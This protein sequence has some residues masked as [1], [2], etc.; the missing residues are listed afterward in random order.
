M[1]QRGA[2]FYSRFRVDG[3][4]IRQCLSADFAQ[5]CVLLR[6]LQAQ[7]DSAASTLPGDDCLWAD[8]VATFL[9]WKRQT[10]RHPEEFAQSLE[11][12]AEYRA[13][14]RV[15]DIDLP[16]VLGFRDWRLAQGVTPRTVNKQVGH[17][18]H[19]L[20][21]AVT[22]KRLDSNPLADVRPLRHDTP[23]KQRRALTLP[24]VQALFAHSPAHLRPVWQMLMTTGLRKREL[25]SLVFDDVDFQRGT[26]TVRAAS[27]KS[28]KARE[29]PLTAE[30][31]T[32]ITQ[33]RA[34][35]ADR[36]PR[37]PSQRRRGNTQ[38]TAFSRDHIF[39]TRANTPWR[40]NLLRAFYA[41]C[42]RAGIAGAEPGGS[43]DLHALRVTFVT[44]AL[45]HGATPRAV[46]EIV[47]HST[48]NLTMGVYARV[49]DTSKRHAVAVLPI[50]CG[51][52]SA[53]T[54]PETAVQTS[55]PATVTGAPARDSVPLGTA[56]RPRT[57]SAARAQTGRKVC[58]KPRRH[59]K[60]PAK[61][62]F[63]PMSF[64]F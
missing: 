16:Y 25:T 14:T 50:S 5:A 46:Q 58:A 15:R 43:V 36:R 26:V 6:E 60:T 23:V 18:R 61:P 53:S 63:S 64:G 19:L 48:L 27:A 24:E 44:L 51:P 37:R 38:Q 13:V 35:A 62:G 56:S 57:P 47:G 11:L 30:M 54:A 32:T 29:V 3:R 42:Q 2:M 49:H 45:E 28:H 7:V 1:Q 39:V 17:L 31:L 40:N 10:S 34:A 20:N 8:L 52:V 22:W 21:M 41:C 33:L 4:L 12:F 9:A 55:L 59:A